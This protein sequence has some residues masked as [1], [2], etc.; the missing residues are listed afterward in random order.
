MLQLEALNKPF[1]E[2]YK[3]EFTMKKVAGII[4]AIFILF[5]GGVVAL[6]TIDINRVGKDTIYVQISEP[7]EVEE[8]RLDSGQIMQRYLYELPAFD[9]KGDM[10]IVQFSAARELREGA[11][12]M[13][14][15]KNDDEVTSYDEVHLEEVPTAVQEQLEE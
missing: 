5:V 3:E 15:V 12:L 6:A 2:G 9:E 4:V 7:V 10:T 8:T 1:Y 13:L 11:Y 14:Y